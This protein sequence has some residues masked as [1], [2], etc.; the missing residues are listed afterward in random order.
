MHH[1]YV[2]AG[3]R[4]IIPE[5]TTRPT[6]AIIART[7]ITEAIVNTAVKTYMRPPITKMKS[8]YACF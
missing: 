1:I 6:A 2:N 5:M 7:S 8:I 4:C 3:N